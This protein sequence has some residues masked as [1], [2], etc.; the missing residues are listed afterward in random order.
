MAVV[1]AFGSQMSVMCQDLVVNRK[2]IALHNNTREIE[3][4]RNKGEE[5]V[6][7]EMRG[8]WSQK[9]NKNTWQEAC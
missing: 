8:V 7:R 5:G 4:G 6:Q 3:F 2:Q 9:R 1:K